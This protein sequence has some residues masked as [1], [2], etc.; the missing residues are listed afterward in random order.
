MCCD[1]TG[2]LTALNG[3]LISSQKGGCV[4]GEKEEC[5][6]ETCHDREAGEMVQKGVVQ[7]NQVTV[8]ATCWRRGWTKFG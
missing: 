4:K 2:G 8:A 1:C 7:Q 6:F 5:D 3:C